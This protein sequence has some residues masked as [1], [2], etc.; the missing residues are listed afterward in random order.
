MSKIRVLQSGHK[1]LI[2]Q[3]SLP[4]Y[5]DF[6]Y[7][8]EIT[9]DLLEEKCIVKDRK[10]P[11][12]LVILG[13]ELSAEEV[14]RLKPFI[15]TYALFVT[16]DVTLR[17]ACFMMYRQKKGKRIL[18]QDLKAF[19]EKEARLFF[20][21]SYGEKF[22]LKNLQISHSF[23]GTVNWKGETMVELTGE[24]GAKWKQ[25]A[26]YGIFIP[27]E[28]YQVLSFWPEYR[29]E[30]EVEL[31]MNITKFVNGSIDT[32][33]NRW[34]F[35]EKMMQEEI[36][37]DS[38]NTLGYLHLS[39]E[40]RGNGKLQIINVHDRYS[41]MQ[42]GY[43][44]PGGNRRVCQNR[45]EIG[46]YFD[47]GDM[48]PPLNVFFSGYKTKEGFEGYYLMKKLGAPFLL[49]ADERLQGGSFYLGSEEYEKTIV[50]EIR[51]KMIELGFGPQD[52]V[53]SGISMGAFGALYYSCDI[54]P[55]NVIVGKP[56]ASIGEIARNTKFIRPN[57][58][59][60]SLDVVYKQCG[61][62]TKEQTYQLD[63]KF[64][65]KFDCADFGRTQFAIAY[66]IEDDYEASAYGKV[67]EH[68]HSEGVSVYGKGLHGRHNDNSAGIVNWFV[69][70]YETVLEQKYDRKGKG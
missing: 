25:I 26:Q 3:Y 30:G 17:D 57:D 36:H 51:A 14:A 11:F 67:L 29:K 55:G 69:S 9:E 34:T 7:V 10:T 19:I 63:K 48:K 62:A 66:M 45:E 65:D 24:F 43:F 18:Q 12:E 28:A 70:R 15:T 1:E 33:E 44:L 41:R 58:F 47:P 16:E 46:F 2:S 31:R 42:H 37:L 40:A 54:S 53:M 35:D 59:T 64:W 39:F 22:E 27:I 61:T 20:Q 8:D 32:V 4:N 50:E 56:L 60:T 49:I 5:L 6:T 68:L 38:G 52:V 21:D 13:R 23:K